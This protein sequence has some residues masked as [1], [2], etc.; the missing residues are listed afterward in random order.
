MNGGKSLFT[1][2]FLLVVNLF[3]FTEVNS[4]IGPPWTWPHR[5]YRPYRHWRSVPIDDGTARV[6]RGDYYY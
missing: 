2:M 4:L 3:L 1:L 6:T 5:P